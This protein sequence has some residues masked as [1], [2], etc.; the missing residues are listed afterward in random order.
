MAQ[1]GGQVVRSGSGQSRTGRS[2]KFD[3]DLLTSQVCS[4]PFF[5]QLFL[6]FPILGVYWGSVVFQHLWFLCLSLQDVRQ[7]I[8]T[9]INWFTIFLNWLTFFSLTLH[10]FNCCAL[11]TGICETTDL[12]A[13]V[14]CPFYTHTQVHNDDNKVKKQNKKKHEPIKPS[15]VPPGLWCPSSGNRKLSHRFRNS[16]VQQDALCGGDVPVCAPQNSS[17]SPPEAREHQN[18]ARETLKLNFQLI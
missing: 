18:V 7:I 12:I 2:E 15:Q 5:F 1:V 4:F 16:A 3:L 11:S 9:A 10:F 6:S 17:R 14:E 8:I 13:D